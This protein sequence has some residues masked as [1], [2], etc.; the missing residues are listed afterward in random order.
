VI[1]KEVQPLTAE[2]ARHF[3][4]SIRRNRL[5]ALLTVAIS[6]GLH[7]D[8][9]KLTYIRLKN[10]VGPEGLEPSTNGL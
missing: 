7:Q 5:E 1:G 4:D 3:L 9:A 2:E 6:I 8:E 10:L